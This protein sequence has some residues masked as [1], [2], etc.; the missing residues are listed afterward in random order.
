M[1]LVGRIRWVRKP[2][3]PESVADP[4]LAILTERRQDASSHLALSGASHGLGA[5]ARS[6]VHE[7]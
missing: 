7:P 6:A 2:I 4:Y 5:A 1:V 3:M